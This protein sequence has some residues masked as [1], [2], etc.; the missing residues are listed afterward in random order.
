MLFKSKFEDCV[1]T[2]DRVNKD[3]VWFLKHWYDWFKNSNK[4]LF[5]IPSWIY[6]RHINT[7]SVLLI[8]LVSSIII[9][10]IWSPISVWTCSSIKSAVIC[11]NSFWIFQETYCSWYLCCESNL[12]CNHGISL[13][14]MC[15]S[16]ERFPQ[17]IFNDEPLSCRSSRCPLWAM[18]FYA[19]NT[20]HSIKTRRY[21]RFRWTFS[22]RCFNME[23]FPHVFSL[24]LFTGS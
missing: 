4:N 10:N 17:L 13:H 8:S 12:S 3:S 24:K 18:F 9:E 23:V 14:L 7:C 2:L 21:S 22:L 16:S 11:N 5:F 19:V 20:K 6:I 1:E 15:K